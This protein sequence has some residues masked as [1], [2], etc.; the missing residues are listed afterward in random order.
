MNKLA[1]LAMTAIATAGITP[2]LS[3]EAAVVSV[4]K[5]P[6]GYIAIGQGSS[7]QDIKDQLMESG[8]NM[9]QINADFCEGIQLPGSNLPGRPEMP[10]LNFPESPALPDYA[11]SDQSAFTEQVVK[12]VNE[13]RAKAGIAPL[14]I[15]RNLQAAADKRAKEIEVSFS[16]TRPD[17][18]GFSTAMTEQ[19]V[20]FTSSGEN[21]AWGQKTP[22]EVMKGWMN[23]AGHRANILNSKFTS[24]GV[25]NYQNGSGTNYWV[26]LF[27]A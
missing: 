2:T 20:T 4:N 14:T 18:S 7:L 25:G 13:E 5:I 22:E 9:N 8:I 17:G 26:Q 3:A 12:L 11:P 16:H 21:I 10:D 6:A 19:G 15:D 27:K 1:I 24:I 23:S